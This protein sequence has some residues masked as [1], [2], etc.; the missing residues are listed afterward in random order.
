M[1]D[2]LGRRWS[3][4]LSDALLDWRRSIT[5][6]TSQPARP[7]GQSMILWIQKMT[8]ASTKRIEVWGMLKI[9]EDSSK[10]EWYG[11]CFVVDS[12]ADKLTL[13][14]LPD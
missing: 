13:Y 5:R 8:Y 9:E 14:I 6:V 3:G 12:A 11:R 10:T 2:R 4:L 7:H 1:L